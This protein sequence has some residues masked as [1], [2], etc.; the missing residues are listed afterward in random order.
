[1][2][3]LLMTNDELQREADAL[4]SRIALG[5]TKAGDSTIVIELANRL[6]R[7]RYAASMDVPV[8]QIPRCPIPDLAFLTII[9]KEAA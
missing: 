8:Q 5:T 7:P 9:A 1:M 4:A 6:L 2:N 3:P